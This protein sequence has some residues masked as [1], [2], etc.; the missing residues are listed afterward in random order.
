MV[1][2]ALLQ[3]ATVR[4]EGSYCDGL[5]NLLV[6]NLECNELRDQGLELLAPALD[7]QKVIYYLST[8]MHTAYILPEYMHAYSY[9]LPQYMHAYSLYTT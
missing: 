4:C 6:L 2:A 7:G 5:G 3:A 9:I 1:A 8:C